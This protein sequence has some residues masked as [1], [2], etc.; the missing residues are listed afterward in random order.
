MKTLILL[1]SRNIH[2]EKFDVFV[3]AV[4]CH[5]AA[6]DAPFAFVGADDFV[7]A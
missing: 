2:F 6:A 3:P 7:A 4:D 5:D 1:M